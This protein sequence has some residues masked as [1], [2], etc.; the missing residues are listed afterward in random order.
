MGERHVYDGKGN[1]I[2]TEVVPDP[3]TSEQIAEREYTDSFAPL[4]VE[5]VLEV[6]EAE[7][8]LLTKADKPAIDAR[9]KAKLAE[10][11]K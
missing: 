5:A 4:I 10:K 1:L 6:M 11:M 2:K 3:P 8:R 7:G 9:A